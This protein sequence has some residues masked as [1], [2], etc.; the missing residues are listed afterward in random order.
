MSVE[1]T[2]TND[3][4]KGKVIAIPQIDNT[5]SK[6]GFGADAKATGDKIKEIETKLEE[7]ET[8]T[9]DKF[10][11]LEGG[12]LSGSLKIKRHDNGFSTVDKNHSAD[13]D[14]GTFIADTTKDG[15]SAKVSVSAGL[16]LLTFTDNT[17][18]IRDIHHEGNKPFGNYTGNGSAT[19]RVIDTKGLGRLCLIYCSDYVVLAT[20][21][22]AFKV[23]LADSSLG[24][25]LATNLYYLNGQLIM[26]TGGEAVNKANETYYYQV[27]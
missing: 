6:E 5:L 15:K 25:I 13:A 20:P 17:S 14:Y 21:K 16:N 9:T 18:N 26:S 22:G 27:I 7:V 24:W 8:N 11:P 19:Q 12:E 1:G 10:L 3:V 2:A 4:L 23:T